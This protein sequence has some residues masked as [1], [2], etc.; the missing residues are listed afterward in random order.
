MADQLTVFQS[1]AQV[2][3]RQ[4]PKLKVIQAT[5]QVEYRQPPK[6]KVLHLLAQVE[7]IPGIPPPPLP[8]ILFG[9]V[10]W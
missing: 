10:I 5:T 9:H 3:F 2:E 6:L 7:Y 8:N 1:L 4:P